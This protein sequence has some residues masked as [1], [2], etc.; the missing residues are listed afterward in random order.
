MSLKV[1]DSVVWSVASA[2]DRSLTRESGS[3]VSTVSKVN[4]ATVRPD[5]RSAESYI[6]EMSRVAWRSEAQ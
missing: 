1:R 4:C 5:S 3:R 6:W 2:S